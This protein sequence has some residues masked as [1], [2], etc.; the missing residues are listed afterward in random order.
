MNTQVPPAPP[1]PPG[2]IGSSQRSSL[3]RRPS[4]PVSAKAPRG[5]GLEVW[6]SSEPLEVWSCSRSTHG[7]PGRAG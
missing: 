4:P 2:Q 6:S 3:A 7:K 1:V 5:V